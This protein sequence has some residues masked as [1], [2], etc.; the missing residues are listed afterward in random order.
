MKHTVI[1]LN[2]FKCFVFVT[3]NTP[4]SRSIDIHWI[5]L[6]YLVHFWDTQQMNNKFKYFTANRRE[7]RITVNRN[8]ARVPSTHSATAYVV[9]TCSCGG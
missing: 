7:L 9:V 4:G 1:E 6:G 8:F 5:S 2:S 3:F